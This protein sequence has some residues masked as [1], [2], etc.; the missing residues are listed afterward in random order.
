MVRTQGPMPLFGGVPGGH[1]SDVA[2]QDG[3]AARVGDLRVQLREVGDHRGIE[4]EQPFRP[5]ESAAAE[6]KLLLSEYSWWIPSGRYG[7]H[8]PSAMT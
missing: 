6:V 3:P 1:G 5:G 8:H 4:I 2:D 7:A